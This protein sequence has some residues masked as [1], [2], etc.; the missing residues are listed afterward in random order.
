M[1]GPLEMVFKIVQH[2]GFESIIERNET[3]TEG[4][5]QLFNTVLG[6]A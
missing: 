1:S 4:M 2:F 6:S 5:E 3:L